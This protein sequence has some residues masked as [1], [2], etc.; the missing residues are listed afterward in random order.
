[1]KNDGFSEAIGGGERRFSDSRRTHSCEK[2]SRPPF[3]PTTGADAMYVM[4]RRKFL[5]GAAQ[6]LGAAGVACCLPRAH[7]AN[8]WA[9]QRIRLGFVGVQGRAGALLQLFSRQPDVEVAALADVDARHLERAMKF[10]ESTAARDVKAHE[11]FR[12]ILDDPSIDVIVIGTPDHWHAIPTIMA[13]AAGK[14]V[15]VEKPDGH[16]MLEGQRMVAAMQRYRR[17][18]QL[19]TQS[20]S[21]PHFAS[22]MDFISSGKLGRVLVAKAWESARQ[23]ALGRPADGDA[24]QGVNYDFWLGPAPLR[25]FNPLRFHGNWRWFFDYGSGDLGNDGVHRLDIARWALETAVRAEVGATLAPLPSKVST[26]GGKWYFDDAQQWPD[27]LQVTYEFAADP[28]PSRIITYEMRIWAPYPYSGEQ[29]GVV[30]YGD[31]AYIVIGNEHWHAYTPDAE[32]IAED[33]GDNA[34]TEHVR[35][36]LDCVKSRGTPRADLATVGHPSSLMCHAANV[37]WRVG[38]SLSLNAHTEQFDDAQADALRTRPEYRSPWTLPE[39]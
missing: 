26:T 12:R 13:C 36:F 24:P 27:T 16:N 32:L 35:D 37:A 20:R 15:Y 2:D 33:Q 5:R 1:M 39:V 3:R 19:G 9:S 21:S 10:V 7:Q 30:L 28:A 11:D 18:V 8:A 23:R 14:D 29:E 38:R 6:S 31:Q 25:R 17:V 22:A 4:N 34:G